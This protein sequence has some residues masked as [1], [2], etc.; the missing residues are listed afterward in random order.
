[1]V[2]MPRT[3]SHRLSASSVFAINGCFEGPDRVERALPSRT[4]RIGEIRVDCA[5]LATSAVLG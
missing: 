1:M 4:C 3:I 2:L 5:L